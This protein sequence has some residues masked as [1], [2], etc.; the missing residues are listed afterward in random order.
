MIFNT[1]EAVKSF[2]N[3]VGVLTEEQIKKEAS[4]CLGCGATIVDQNKC[5]GC[6]I[7]TTKCNI[8]TVMIPDILALKHGFLARVLL[9]WIFC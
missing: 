5:I 8:H 2:K 9:M 4:K 7:C 1:A 3:P 6:G